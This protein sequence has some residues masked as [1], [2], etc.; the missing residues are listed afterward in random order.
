MLRFAC[1][2][3]M[4]FSATDVASASKV[5]LSTITRILNGEVEDPHPLTAQA[6]DQLMA[7]SIPDA[8]T[9]TVL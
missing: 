3:G 6:L 9:K 1:G 4:G 8:D 2:A 5:S 7:S